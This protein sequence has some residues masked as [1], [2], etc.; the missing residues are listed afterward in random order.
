MFDARALDQDVLDR[1]AETLLATG[2]KDIYR[3]QDV[4]YNATEPTFRYQAQVV[5]KTVDGG[6]V[7]VDQYGLEVEPPTEDHPADQYLEDV[8]EELNNVVVD[9]VN[10]DSRLAPECGNYSFVYTNRSVNLMFFSLGSGQLEQLGRKIPKEPT[11]AHRYTGA[12]APQPGRKARRNKTMSTR[13]DLKRRIKAARRRASA[14]RARPARKASPRQRP[15]K[16]AP[17]KR[18]VKAA[19]KRAALLRRTARLRRMLRRAETELKR[20]DRPTPR[21]RARSERPSLRERLEARRAQREKT[22]EPMRPRTR[23]ARK[24]KANRRVNPD[25]YRIVRLKTGEKILVQRVADAQ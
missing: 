19:P 16:A 4:Y 23:P 20:L 21:R 15:V 24:A 8:A 7:L 9:D 1:Y 13:E 5:A 10:D 17:R 18:P 25:D 11:E 12:S 14:K 22:S 3:D 6:A 2:P